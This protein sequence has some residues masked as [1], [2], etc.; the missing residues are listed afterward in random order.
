MLGLLLPG[1]PVIEKEIYFSHKTL[2][3]LLLSDP[4]LGRGV[5][6]LWS[7]SAVASPRPRA[8]PGA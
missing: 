3:F 2:V 4:S 6:A 1:V 5:A 8:L 7:L